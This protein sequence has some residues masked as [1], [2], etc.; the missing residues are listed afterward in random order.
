MRRR[1]E[2]FVSVDI[3]ASGP[4]PGEYSLL[5]IGACDAYQPQNVFSCFLKPISD[6]AQDEALRVTGLS[7]AALKKDGLEPSTAMLK[8]EDWIGGVA[9]NQK[10]VFVG[11]NAAFDWSF[12]N[13][14]FHRYLGRNPFG[15]AALDIKSLYM[16]AQKCRWDETSADNITRGLDV[17]RIKRH[18]ALHDAV[19]QAE[20]FRYV[21]SLREE[22]PDMPAR[23]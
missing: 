5:Q 10:V 3:E 23:K 7:M 20:L 22:V 6:N 18:D 13:Y 14:Y 4:I 1:P 11:L 9:K 17:Q 8:F 2:L 21:L 15:H 12:I 16:G 19:F